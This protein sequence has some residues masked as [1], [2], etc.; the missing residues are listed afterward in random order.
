MEPL[1][2]PHTRMK[3]HRSVFI[4]NPPDDE[5][6]LHV[7]RM[8]AAVPSLGPGSYFCR[9]SAS[10]VHGLPLWFANLDLVHVVRTQGGH[11]GLSPWIHAY[12]TPKTLPATTLIDGFRVTTLERTAA[13]VMRTLTFGPTLAVA[14]AVLRIGGSRSAL[15]KEVE[16]G[17]GCRHCTEAVLRADPLSESPYESWAR[18]IMLQNQI[19]LPKLQVEFFDH[20]GFIGRVDFHWPRHRLIGE[21]DGET[22]YNELLPL[23]ATRA[24]AEAAAALRQG[25]IEALGNRFIRFGKEEVHDSFILAGRLADE[26]GDL[27]VDHG[28]RPEAMDYRRPRRRG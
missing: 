12:T 11:G 27:R 14:D 25:R 8:H 2:Q 22:K 4:T 19:P 24:D 18:A 3:L 28:L 26:F 21:Y 20:V 17:R 1:E 6:A 23:G 7:E 10:L 15:L 5:R 16:K 9:T 13:D